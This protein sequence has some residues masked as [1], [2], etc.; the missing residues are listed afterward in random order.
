MRRV[1]ITC[2][3]CTISAATGIGSLARYG[4]DAWPPLPVTVISSTSAD[5]ISAPPRVQIDARRQVRRD[6]QRERG[7]DR[8][9]TVEHALVDHVP[10]AV[11]ALFAGLEHEAN[12]ARQTRRGAHASSRAAPTSIAV[13]A[14]CPH[15]CMQPST[16]LA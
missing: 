1:T 7:V 9:V 5:A 16:S 12:G 4:V 13:C 2:S 15:A 8:R 14:S 10:R 11:E 3:A 6:V